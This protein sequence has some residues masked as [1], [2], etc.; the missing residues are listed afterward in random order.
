MSNVAN[1]HD[2]E[3]L[4]KTSVFF[5]PFTVA[6]AAGI[7]ASLGTTSP[8]RAGQFHVATAQDLQTALFT[9]KSN[10]EDDTIYFAA[11]IYSGTFTFT[12]SEAQS[13]SLLPETNAPTGQVVLSG[14]LSLTA[15]SAPN[16][17]VQ[18]ITFQS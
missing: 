13:L 2:P 1:R 8:A 17:T 12:S 18:G 6:L 11:G 7:L 15:L 16:V 3:V 10:G 4:M 14:S 9:A 5:S